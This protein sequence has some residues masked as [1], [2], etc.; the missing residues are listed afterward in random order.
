MQLFSQVSW[1]IATKLGMC[2]HPNMVLD[3]FKGII[4]LTPFRG[5]FGLKTQKK[6]AILPLM[7]LF[8]QVSWWMATKLCICIHPYLNRHDT[9]RDTASHL[10]K[11]SNKKN[12]TRV[13]TDQLPVVSIEVMF[14]MD[15]KR[16]FEETHII[17]LKHDP[18]RH[19]RQLICQHPSVVF[20]QKSIMTNRIKGLLEV[21]EWYSHCL[22]FLQAIYYIFFQ[23]HYGMLSAML[24]QKS[25]LFFSNNIESFKK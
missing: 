18:N 25:K 5:H 1:W 23:V 8:S 21:L 9:F 20:F 13:L 19:H 11:L 4:D 6:L 7:Q 22:I 24:L 14:Y 16:K 15:L 10:L 2:I 12:N 3:E 17:H